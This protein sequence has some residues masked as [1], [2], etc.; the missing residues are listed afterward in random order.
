MNLS[1]CIIKPSLVMLV[2]DLSR[3]GECSLSPQQAGVFLIFLA[4]QSLA[5]TR[6]VYAIVAHVMCQVIA[7]TVRIRHFNISES[8]SPSLIIQFIP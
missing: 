4:P 1:N 8:C 6:L 2:I 3:G 7:G 5:G